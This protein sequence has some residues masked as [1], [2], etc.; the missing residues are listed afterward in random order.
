MDVIRLQTCV[1]ISTEDCT[2][3]M[4]P[5]HTFD[6]ASRVLQGHN[7]V[8]LTTTNHT[9]CCW[10]AVCCILLLSRATPRQAV[11]A[12]EAYI[13]QHGLDDVQVEVETRNLQELQEVGGNGGAQSEQLRSPAAE[14]SARGLN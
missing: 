2:K 6:K 9:G 13:Q 14:L 10:L 12:A 11:A 8:F 1:T 7:R 5:F 3:R 4:L